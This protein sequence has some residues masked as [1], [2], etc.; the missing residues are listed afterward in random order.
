MGLILEIGR[1]IIEY[2][3]ADFAATIQ[4]CKCHLEEMPTS[5]ATL[6]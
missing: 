5:W 2:D 3:L 1:T 6:K 4:K